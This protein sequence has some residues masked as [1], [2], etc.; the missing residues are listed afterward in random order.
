M[1]TAQRF[2]GVPGGAAGTGGLRTRLPSG[3]GHVPQNPRDQFLLA[4]GAFTGAP[5]K[6]RRLPDVCYPASGPSE[7]A[8]PHS[9]PSLPFRFV[10]VGSTGRRNT[11]A[12]ANKT[13]RIIWAVLM[14]QEDYKAPI[15][16]A[17]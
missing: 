17:A 16:A 13:A 9:A 10:P 15:A 12:L 4:V 3:S 8:S 7:G 14:K 5:G 1:P 11:F 2:T 6:P